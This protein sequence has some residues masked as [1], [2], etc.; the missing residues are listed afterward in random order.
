MVTPQEFVKKFG[1]FPST[2]EE[3]RAQ[4]FV[5]RF[6]TPGTAPTK[7][8]SVGDVVVDR[9]RFISVGEAARMEAERKAEADR[10]A[11]EQKRIAD[12]QRRVREQ[13]DAEA[14]AEAEK[15]KQFQRGVVAQQKVEDLRRKIIREGGRV[16]EVTRKENGKDVILRTT[17]A[18][19]KLG[20]E[21][22]FEKIDPA[23][24]RTTIKTFEKG[25]KGKVRR[26]GG[27]I[28]QK[29]EAEPAIIEERP[30]SEVQPVE[31]LGGI[32]GIDQFIRSRTDILSTTVRRGDPTFKERAELLGLSAVGT[33][34]GAGI[35]F[36]ELGKGL[37][38]EPVE[39]VKGLPAGAQTFVK[40]TGRV[41]RTGSPE[42]IVGRGLGEVAV[43]KGIGVG[44]KAIGRTG[45][46]ARTIPKL[47]LVKDDFIKIPSE[48]AGRE[49]VQIEIARGVESTAL[50]KPVQVR[51][52][53]TAQDVV[54][55]QRDLF[56]TFRR[57]VDI[58]KPSLP[59]APPLEQAF[60]ADPLARLRTS[61]F[62]SPEASLTEILGGEAQFQFK[63]PRAQAV[64]VEQTKIAKFP[65]S[66]DV[67]RRKLLRGEELTAAD[68]IKLLNFQ[69]T[70]TGEFKPIGFVSREAEVTL[71]PGE[72]LIKKKVEARA[73]VR[74][75]GK[76]RGVDVIRAEIGKT[77]KSKIKNLK[78]DLKVISSELKAGKITEPQAI[79]K[80]SG[81]E[82]KLPIRRP[83]RPT[84]PVSDLPS[85]AV[86]PIARGRPTPRITSPLGRPLK[87][88]TRDQTRVL[89]R[90]SQARG[91]VRGSVPRI[92]PRIINPRLGI[93]PRTGRPAARVVPPP[94]PRI[95]AEPE[96]KVTRI[97]KKKRKDLFSDDIFLAEG[98]VSR[99]LKLGKEKIK[100]ED[101]GAALRRRQ[102][103]LRL[104]P[105]IIDKKKK[106]NLNRIK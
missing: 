76:L 28:L 22:I 30:I 73:F 57:T 49:A 80:I 34:F 68:R 75:D 32:L 95:L 20:G 62:R 52:A 77:P 48:I 79:K 105:V 45:E 66:L 59:G 38:T 106:I 102:L 86:S 17:R 21:R 43:F 98:F 36:F 39:T 56:T 61:R 40:E 26:T 100:R 84:I 27:V 41:L 103:G 82:S 63:R 58:D 81:V 4:E 33:V 35:G 71:A 101:I 53:G 104:A 90:A 8:V 91:V 24:G 5:E 88:L 89:R 2:A 83:S 10:I 97:K 11:K 78:G 12:E 50:P 72:R 3:Q 46:F 44:Q 96:F 87:R 13:R 16:E 42:E 64:F 37:L 9:G 60:F 70:P 18:P 25:A 94:V 93:P 29:E 99:A 74:V 1:P 23:T 6:G 51:L 69:L 85:R 54:S 15:Q 92:D 67:V 47:K 65:K 55:A 31:Q 19:G 7:G 14:K